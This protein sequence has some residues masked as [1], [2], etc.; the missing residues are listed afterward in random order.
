[1]S[2]DEA[3]AVLGRDRPMR[4]RFGNYIDEND[5]SLAAR[6]RRKLLGQKENKPAK[7]PYKGDGGLPANQTYHTKGETTKYVPTG[8]DVSVRVEALSAGAQ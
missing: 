7:T 5:T 2:P 1:M 6:T 3:D 8:K 4:D